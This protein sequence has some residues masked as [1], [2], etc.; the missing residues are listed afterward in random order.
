MHI[1]TQLAALLAVACT[2]QAVAVAQTPNPFV[3]P[4]TIGPIPDAADVVLALAVPQRTER[5]AAIRKAA[6]AKGGTLQLLGK[7]E[8]PALAE[9]LGFYCDRPSLTRHFWINC[10]WPRP[11]VQLMHDERG[12]PIDEDYTSG[13]F[14]VPGTCPIGWMCHRGVNA[15]GEPTFGIWTSKSGRSEP[16]VVCAPSP[17]RPTSVW[18]GGVKRHPEAVSASLSVVKAGNKKQR[19]SPP[20]QAIARQAESPPDTVAAI[21]DPGSSSESPDRPLTAADH[22]QGFVLDWHDPNRRTTIAASESPRG[23][24]RDFGESSQSPAAE[25][26]AIAAADYTG[27][28]ELAWTDWLVEDED[29]ITAAAAAAM[30]WS[31]AAIHH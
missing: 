18:K 30:P 22:I 12:I 7:I 5:E 8:C 19:V 6:R 28:L 27:Q 3:G 20:T 31:A 26:E 1:V 29:D 16:T 9:R 25:L 15:F 4:N 14:R 21:E 11:I 23:T 13:I 17:R 10:R 2:R 24:L